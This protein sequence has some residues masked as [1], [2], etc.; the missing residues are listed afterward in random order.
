MLLSVQSGHTSRYHEAVPVRVMQ[1]VV[2]YKM[3]NAFIHTSSEEGTKELA[4]AEVSAAS[5]SGSVP[6]STG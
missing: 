6:T 5:V 4:S 2:T 3:K 1:T